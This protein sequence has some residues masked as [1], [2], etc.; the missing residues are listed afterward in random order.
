MHKYI[1][2]GSTLTRAWQP[3]TP[4]PITP[5]LSAASP[6]PKLSPSLA[7]LSK[8][9]IPQ[10]PKSLFQNPTVVTG[11]RTPVTPLESNPKNKKSGASKDTFEYSYTYP[12]QLFQADELRRTYGIGTDR[13]SK[14]LVDSDATENKEVD[15]DE[16]CLLILKHKKEL[17]AKERIEWVEAVC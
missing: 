5:L 7:N 14:I 9:R 12:N 13:K 3:Y 11:P 16:D 15:S 10:V 2:I 17:E 4:K 8:K 1:Y 6:S